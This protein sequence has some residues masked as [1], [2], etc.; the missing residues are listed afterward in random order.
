LPTILQR[1]AEAIVRH[2]DAAFARIW[3]LDERQNILELQAS[4]GLYTRLDG[5]HARVA[6]GNLKIGRIAQERRPHL[7]NDVQNDEHISHP[8]WA[9]QEG[10]V[11]FAGYPLV[12]EG[13]LV[14]LARRER[15]IA[16]AQIF[17]LCTLLARCPIGMNFARLT[18][19]KFPASEMAT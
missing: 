7:T 14:A 11:A 5:E 10:M 9:K 6:V 1:S 15:F 18:R 8:E 13:R 4:A 12:V 2:L 19:A 17:K 3:T 16:P